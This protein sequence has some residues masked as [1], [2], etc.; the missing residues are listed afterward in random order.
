[1]AI[2]RNHFAPLTAALLLGFCSGA[3]GDNSAG[4]VPTKRVIDYDWMSVKAWDRMHAEDVLVAQHDEVDALFLGD[5]ITAGWDYTIWQ[6]R[7]VPLKA[8]NF[9]IGGDHTGN[10]LWRLQHGA[11][12]NLQPKVIVVLIGVNNFGHLN[13]NPEQ[14]AAGVRAVVEQ[15]KL[16]WPT[17]KILLNAVFPYEQQA[18]SPR[19]AHVKQLNNAIKKL[20][21]NNLVFFRDYG[22]LMLEKDGSISSAVM[23]DFLHPT[24]LGYQRWADAM[25]PDLEQLLKP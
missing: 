10:L 12:G 2:L 3:M 17:A 5:S 14:T 19:R 25:Q 7:F 18:S 6:Q 11:I 24:A 8:A 1:M 9:G 23:A 22:H 20:A 21:D 4:T 13:E 16:A 15:I